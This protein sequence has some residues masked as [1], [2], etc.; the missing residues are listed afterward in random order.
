MVTGRQ[1]RRQTDG[2]DPRTHATIIRGQIDSRAGGPLR[3]KVGGPKCAV[4]LPRA[5]PAPSRPLMRVGIV[6]LGRMG[7]HLAEQAIE[8]GHSIVGFDPKGVPEPLVSKGVEA[9]TS[10]PALI[11]KLAPPRIVFLYVPHGEITERV[12]SELLAGLGDGDVLVDGGNSH[13]RDSARRAAGARRAGV[14]FLDVGTSG[15]VEGARRGACFM[16]GG[17]PGAFTVVEPILRDLAVPEGLAHVGP[18]GAGH[19]AKLIHNAIE[20]GMV[21]AIGEGIELL[22]RS[23]Y[24]YDL[25]ALFHNWAHGSVIRGWLVELM[26]RALRQSPSFDALS[27]YVEDTREVRW[28]VEYALEKEV[29]IPVIAQSEMAFYRYRDP[30]SLTGKMIALLRHEFGGHP[31]HRTEPGPK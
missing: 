20:F 8:K 16:V 6:G 14:Q 10:L 7:S 13:W 31:V 17:E 12:F 3:T 24:P 19:F 22:V 15:G 21:Q 23:D 2:E 27:G 1:R 4:P 18:A 29:W 30:D 28:A 9:A 5:K 25:A 11:D 26:E